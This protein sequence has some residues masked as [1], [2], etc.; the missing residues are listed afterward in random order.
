[1]NII[2]KPGQ[3]VQIIIDSKIEDEGTIFVRAINSIGIRREDGTIFS[4]RDPFTPEVLRQI[5]QK[6][7]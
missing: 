2:P 7:G 3:K 4:I 1:M 5:L 6:K